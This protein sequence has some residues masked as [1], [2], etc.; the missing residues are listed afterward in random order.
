MNEFQAVLNYMI[1]DVFGNTNTWI[2][3]GI[4]FNTTSGNY[5]WAGSCI[6]PTLL[7]MFGGSFPGPW[8][9]FGYAL[10]LDVKKIGVGPSSYSTYYL[11]EE[12]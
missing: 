8:A 11:C 5:W 1:S 10:K 3:L 2:W 9:G 6:T 12:Y 4:E 7:E